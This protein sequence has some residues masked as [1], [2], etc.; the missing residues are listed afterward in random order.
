MNV[1]NFFLILNK[2]YIFIQVLL[3]FYSVLLPQNVLPC[4]FTYTDVN[5]LICDTIQ[6]I[7]WEKKNQFYKLLCYQFVEHI[8]KATILFVALWFFDLH[9]WFINAFLLYRLK[10]Y[11]ISPKHLGVLLFYCFCQWIY[12]VFTNIQVV[13]RNV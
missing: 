1:I 5:E 2:I 12:L 11:K 9:F 4:L 6:V 10:V 7:S 3:N 13:K 8:T